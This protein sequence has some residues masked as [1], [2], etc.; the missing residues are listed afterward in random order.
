MNEAETR[1]EHIDPALKAAG[2]GVVEGSKILREYRITLGRIE[3]AGRRGLPLI[4]DYVLV[5]RN[6]KLAVNEAKAWVDSLMPLSRARFWMRSD[7]RR[8]EVSYRLGDR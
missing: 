4:A 5:Y 1:A 6:H 7:G 8:M 3:G 2:W